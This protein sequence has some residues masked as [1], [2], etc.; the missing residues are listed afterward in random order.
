MKTLRTDRLILKVLDQSRA[1]QVL[2]YYRRNQVFLERWEPARDNNFY[3]KD[4]QRDNLKNELKKIKNDSMYRWWI[5]KIEDTSR[6]IGSIALNNIIRGCFQSCFL[7]YKLDKDEINNGYMTEALT[8]I[9]YFAFHDL[10]LHR[11]EANIM[12]HNKPSLRVVEKLGFRK[13]G[14]A[15]KYLK[16]NGKWEDH[17]CMVLL[18]EDLE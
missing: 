6:V 12:P 7:G 8:R 18:N 16:I 4:F 17:L 3:T 14:L 15:R 11:L 2:A 5:Y 13:E 1:Q 9:I 10:R